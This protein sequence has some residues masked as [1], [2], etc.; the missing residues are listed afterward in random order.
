MAYVVMAF[1]VM[2]H[3]VIAYI[4]I[5]YVVMAYISYGIVPA[6]NEALIQHDLLVVIDV[7]SEEALNA[8]N[9]EDSLPLWPV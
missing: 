2:A 9:D 6:D 3:I 7:A 8:V 5:T 4:V 1:I